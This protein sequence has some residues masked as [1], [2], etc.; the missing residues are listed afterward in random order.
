M[1][2]ETIEF[3]EM[4]GRVLDGLKAGNEALKTLEQEMS[5]EAVEAILDDARDGIAYANVCRGVV[6]V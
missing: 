3:K 2:A 4:E 5:I 1:Q 6:C